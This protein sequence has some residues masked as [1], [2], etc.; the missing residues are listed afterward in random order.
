MES[1]TTK[2]YCVLNGPSHMCRHYSDY[3]ICLHPDTECEFYRGILGKRCK[4]VRDSGM[5]T[6]IKAQDDA[7]KPI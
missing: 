3:G 6:S 5:C 4:D 7:A 2:N 1:K